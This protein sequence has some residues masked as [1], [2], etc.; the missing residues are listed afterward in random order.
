MNRLTQ[1]DKLFDERVAALHGR[2]D[3]ARDRWHI[4]TKQARQGQVPC[5]ATAWRNL[6]KDES[7]PWREVCLARKAEW[8]R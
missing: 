5:F 7:C 1:F 6:C 2:G 8:Q 4:W 3:A